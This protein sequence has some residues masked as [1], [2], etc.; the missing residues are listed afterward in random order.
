METSNLLPK[1]AVDEFKQL[2]KK[3]FKKEISDEEANRRA[4]NLF[5]LYEAVYSK[6][7]SQKL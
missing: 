3:L 4:N 1:D 2:Y 7:K 5:A 6:N